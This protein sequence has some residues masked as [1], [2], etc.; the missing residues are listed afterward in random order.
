[1][2]VNFDFLDRKISYIS[3]RK[4]LKTDKR[5]ETGESNKLVNPCATK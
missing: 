1:M 3:N 2:A 5:V 4:I